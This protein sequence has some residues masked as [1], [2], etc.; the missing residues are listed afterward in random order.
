M[1]YQSCGTYEHQIVHQQY[2][3]N[4]CK[5]SPILGTRWFCF[6]CRKDGKEFNLCNVCKIMNIH[7]HSLESVKY[8]TVKSVVILEPVDDPR[9]PNDVLYPHTEV[10]SDF[11]G[12]QSSVN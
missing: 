4:L 8:S 1:S 10:F 6:T 3:C 5:C 12:Y 7:S 11:V 9:E 2:T